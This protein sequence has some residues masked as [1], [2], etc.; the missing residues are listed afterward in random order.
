MIKYHV[1]MENNMK[2]TSFYR[3]N[4]TA[5]VLD[6]ETASF[7]DSF[8]GDEGVA[9]VV[10]SLRHNKYVHTLD[11]RGNSIRNNGIFCIADLIQINNT[12]KTLILGQYPTHIPLIFS[13]I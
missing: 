8:L 13:C 6:G 7:G 4:L 10:E 9:T 11:L 3:S 2:T 1:Y 5:Y 12:I